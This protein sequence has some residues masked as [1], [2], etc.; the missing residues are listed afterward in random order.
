FG[1]TGPTKGPL[2]AILSGSLAVICSGG[3]AP[4]SKSESVPPS[5]AP[6]LPFSSGPSRKV[7]FILAVS[8]FLGFKDGRNSRAPVAD[9]CT[10]RNEDRAV[11]PGAAVEEVANGARLATGV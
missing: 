7:G 9:C 3:A 10:V 5:T 8:T 11:E 2:I 1:I 4:I 6:F